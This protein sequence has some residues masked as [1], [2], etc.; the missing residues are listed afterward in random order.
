[1]NKEQ[2]L[3]YIIIKLEKLRKEKELMLDKMLESKKIEEDENLRIEYLKSLYAYEQMLDVK[4]FIETGVN[5]D[6]EFKKEK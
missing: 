2:I 6:Y 1:M 4:A 5:L 3:E